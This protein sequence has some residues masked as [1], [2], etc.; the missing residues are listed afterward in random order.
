MLIFSIELKVDRI[1]KLRKKYQAKALAA[2]SSGDAVVE[3]VPSLLKLLPIVILTEDRNE[4][5]Q[6]LLSYSINS[7]VFIINFTVSMFF[8]Q[9]SVLS[10][11][12][13]V[14]K[15]FLDKCVDDVLHFIRCVTTCLDIN[16]FTSS[17]PLP[18]GV[19]HGRAL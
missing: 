16:W 12:Y 3:S 10:V 9:C 1:I 5:F 13:F 4:P 18:E 17:N 15:F 8:P 11:A 19:S 7:I 14:L 2:K 6:E